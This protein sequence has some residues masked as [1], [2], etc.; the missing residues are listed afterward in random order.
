[1]SDTFNLQP[2]R[3][4]RT[5]FG[6]DAHEEAISDFQGLLKTSL[7]TLDLET[8]VTETELRQTIFADLAIGQVRWPKSLGRPDAS[9]LLA[10]FVFDT[11]F[12]IDIWHIGLDGSIVTDKN[13]W[14]Q[15]DAPSV[16]DGPAESDHYSVKYMFYAANQNDNLIE[17]RF[18]AA[19]WQNAGHSAHRLPRRYLNS[20]GWQFYS[21]GKFT[22]LPD[23]TIES[24][25]FSLHKTQR[26]T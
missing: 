19:H 18:S 10:G 5:N 21:A 8:W 1:M 13:G 26:E 6:L 15:G 7:H 24:R 20:P 23:I 17:V 9:Q 22:A 25:P 3:F 4:A 12:W 16:W 2:L 11:Q 14:V